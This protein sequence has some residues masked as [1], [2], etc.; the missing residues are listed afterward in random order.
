ML[1]NLKTIFFFFFNYFL[2]MYH[3]QSEVTSR[4]QT[5]SSSRRVAGVQCRQVRKAVRDVRRCNRRRA[6]RGNVAQGCSLRKRRETKMNH[7]GKERRMRG[8]KGEE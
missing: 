2:A 8:N 1:V 7:T 3:P 5:Q 6:V 4:N